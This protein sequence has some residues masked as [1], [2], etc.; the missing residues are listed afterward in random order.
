M[1]SLE[2]YLRNCFCSRIVYGLVISQGKG[3]GIEIRLWDALG[4]EELSSEMP[5]IDCGEGHHCFKFEN[6]NL[7]L[8]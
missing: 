6:N 3:L 2:E 7:Q 4:N 8:L 1:K 5:E